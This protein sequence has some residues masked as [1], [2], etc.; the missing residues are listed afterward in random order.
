MKKNKWIL[1]V[2]CTLG[3][4]AFGFAY[5]YFIGCKSGSCPITSNPWIA[6]AWM[7]VVGYLVSVMFSKKEDNTKD[8][9][10]EEE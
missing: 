10:N 6:T 9:S 7:A 8:E 3:G 5:Y 4:A 2:A 1:P